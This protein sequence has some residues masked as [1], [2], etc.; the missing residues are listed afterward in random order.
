MKVTV[1]CGEQTRILYGSEHQT[2]LELL[3]ING[4]SGVY[5]PCG[6]N[7]TCGKCLVN[8]R[9]SGPVL[10]CRTQV[11]DNMY[12][13]VP[14]ENRSAIAEQ[15]DCC[16]YK[17]DWNFEYTAAC[18][19][20]T[21]TVVCHLMEGGSGRRLATVSAPNA[22][23]TFGADV[24]SRIQAAKEGYLNQLHFLI[25]DQINHML[26]Q[27]CEKAGVRTDIAC[28]AVSGNTVMSHLFVGIS[29]ETIGVSPF[30]P[31][32]LFGAVYEAS[33]LGI[34]HCR[35]VYI[36]PSVSGYVGGDITA[37]M[38]AAAMKS[39][40]E[41][42]RFE[43]TGGKDGE[44]LLLD[45]GTNGEIVLGKPGDYL[46]C[47]AAAGPAFEG[48]EIE[49]GMSAAQGAI[50]KVWCEHGDIFVSVIGGGKAAGLCGSGLIDA[51]AVFL[52][53]GLMD[54]TGLLTDADEV[55]ESFRKYIGKDEKGSCVY[56]TANVRVTQGDIRKLQLAK[57][58]VAAGIDILLAER[59]ISHKDVS[60]V[61]LAGGFGSY[62]NKKSAAAIGMIPAELLGVTYSVGNAAG[63][64]AVSAAVSMAAR[65]ELKRLQNEMQY[66]E[67]STHP[68]FSDAYIDEIYFE[69]IA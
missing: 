22:Q 15:G 6:G 2:L 19:I 57:A 68:G 35:E 3:Q 41:P 36:A 60:R 11:T 4:I 1:C 21:T 10:A 46:C 27:L 7:G 12:I 59:H 53:T 18:D 37:D 49:M 34:A 66:V 31:R 25:T 51:L 39:S 58:S 56:L 29:P 28:L 45:I 9:E 52:E 5:A 63:E 33:A 26:E 44:T 43:D 24:I 42:V 67:L 62:L 20:G 14:K 55:E 64:G 32:S 61:I 47:A 13:T 69:I 30:L 23:R 38:L 54:E 8:V 50:S 48:A 65:E 40:A 17:A 16:L